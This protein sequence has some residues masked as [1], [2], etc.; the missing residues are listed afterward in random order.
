MFKNEKSQIEFFALTRKNL[1]QKCFKLR[2][3][4]KRSGSGT[5]QS[6]LNVTVS[7]FLLFSLKKQDRFDRRGKRFC[8]NI[9]DSM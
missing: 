6:F 1:I 7:I 4:N 5:G 2:A 9:F 3:P 8:A